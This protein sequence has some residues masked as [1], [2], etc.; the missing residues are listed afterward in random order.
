MIRTVLAS[1]ANTAIL[2]LQDVLGLGNKAR[3][4]HPGTVGSN[5]AWRCSPRALTDQLANRLARLVALY[6]R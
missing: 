3:M 4:N 2:P 1:V 6:E 5:W